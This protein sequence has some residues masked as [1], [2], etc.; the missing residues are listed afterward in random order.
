MKKGLYITSVLLLLVFL[1]QYSVSGNQKTKAL[2]TLT[3]TD[4]ACKPADITADQEDVVVSIDSNAQVA[5]SISCDDGSFVEGE[6]V[7]WKIKSGKKKISVTPNSA[8][9]DVNG[10]AAFTITGVK[11]GKAIVEFKSVDLKVKV[12]VKIAKQKKGKTVFAERWESAQTGTYKPSDKL[13]VI[14]ADEGDWF[15]GDTVTDNGCGSTPHKVKV[16]KENG[17]NVLHL[18]SNDSDS[19][20]A[21]NIFVHIGNYGDYNKGF[22]ISFNADTYLSFEETGELFNPERR[23]WTTDSCLTPPCFDSVTMSLQDT[24]GN[25]LTYVFQRYSDAEPNKKY[26]NYREV[27]LDPDAGSYERNLFDDFL[28]IPAFDSSDTKGHKIKYISFEV[29]EH[30]WAIFDNIVFGK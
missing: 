14:S 9:T 17:S 29:N 20:C 22:G 2:Q 30:G 15:M 23:G 10:Q 4:E 21:D 19:S 5:I 27:F 18:I 6:Q 13:P 25:T 8:T 1:G 3:S 16:Y 28:T 24:R 26:E 7:T 12:K 11:K